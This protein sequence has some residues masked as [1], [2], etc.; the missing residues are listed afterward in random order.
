MIK[1]LWYAALILGGFC[2][3]A[4]AGNPGESAYLF[5]YFIKNGEDGLHLAWSGDGY[6]WNAVRD[7]RSVLTPTVGHKEKLMRDPCVTRG[8]DG[9]YHI[10]WTA[11]WKGDHIGYASTRDF[12]TWS[13]QR[14][15]R[16]MA[17]EPTVRNCW[18]PEIIY[19]GKKGEFVIFWSSTI[20]GRFPGTGHSESDLNHRIYCTT[21]RDFNTFT[22]TRLFY[23]PGFSV[24]DATFLQADGRL[25]LIVKDERIA[26]PRKYLQMAEAES[27]SGPFGALSKPFSPPGMWVEGPT[28]L[29]IGDD[30]LVY[31]DA[32]TTHRYGA[33]RSRD[34]KNWEDV[35]AKMTFPFA[36]TVNRM[37][38]GTVVE[39][40]RTLV[41]HLCQSPAAAACSFG[42][43]LIPDLIAD[44]S[45]VDVD[46]TFYCY[47]TTD[48]AGAGLA[49]S[50]LP[51]VWKSKDFLNWDFQGS[52]FSKDF[53]AKY[54]APSSLVRKNGRYYLFPTLNERITVVVADSPEGPFRTVDG[55]DIT[56]TS[57]WKP[58]P[59]TVGKPIDAEVFVDD[60]GKA[61]MVWARRGIC[62]LQDDL[63]APDGEQTLVK[64][65]RQGYSEG[66]FLFK[67]KGIYYYL[68]TLGGNENYQYAYMMSRTSPLGPWEAPEKDIIATT[69][70]DQ[71]IYGPGHGCFFTPKGSDQWFFVYLEF[72]RGGTTRQVWAD[73]M[74]FNDDGTIKPVKLSLQGVG[75][76]RPL[77]SPETNLALGKTTTVSSVMRDLR[78]KPNQDPALDRVETFVAANALDGSNGTRWLALGKDTN[79]WYQVDLGEVRDIKRTELYFVKPT[80]GHAYRLDYSLDGKTWQGYGGHVSVTVQSPHR[81]TRSVR[82]RYLRLAIL[83]GEPGLW[84][85]KVY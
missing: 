7:G 21:T 22:P 40:P 25:H 66:P 67:R 85:F 70:H 77:E 68:Y 72:G 38:H 58:F 36:G 59:I 79:A 62:R 52:I 33:M 48:G 2:G 73:R 27:C 76:L 81:D 71:K 51:V 24:I 65:K 50:G 4:G 61:F 6:T 44:P 43:P 11:G 39:V 45:V 30:Y 63:T 12:I 31:F 57:G 18:A 5:T 80:G 60:D 1:S 8:P 32:Y 47:A 20:P 15:L 55:K 64:T 3:V 56:K 78:V 23:D 26:P 82:A 84:E 10:V 14:E 75:A 83:H 46:G 69:D 74:E 19:D 49:T 28:A 42:H 16:V 34:L 17:H 41:D 9:T 54:W 53:D 29:K 37:R 13:E 35:S